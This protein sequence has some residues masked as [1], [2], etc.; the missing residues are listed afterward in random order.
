[1][2]DRA[3]AEAGGIVGELLLQHIGR[4]RGDRRPRAG[5][6]P[7]EGAEPGTAQ[8]RTDAASEIVFGR[9]EVRHLGGEDAPLLVLAEIA[10]DLADREPADRHQD[11]ADS[12]R[13]LGYSRSKALHPGVRSGAGDP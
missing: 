11:K 13:W 4:K 2:L 8:D 5:Q 6:H 1:P 9:P 12:V 10:D 7:E 3:F